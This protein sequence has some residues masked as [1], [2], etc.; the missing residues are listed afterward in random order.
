MPREEPMW[1]TLLVAADQIEVEAGPRF[2]RASIINRAHRLDPSHHEMAYGAMF[3]TMVIESPT[4]PASPVGKV[5]HR[6]GHGLYLNASS[7]NLET[8]TKPLN[9]KEET[10]GPKKGLPRLR[11]NETSQRLLS[12]TAGFDLY[13]SQ[14]AVASPFRRS[15]QLDFHRATIV[16]RRTLGTADAALDDEEFLDTLYA[17]LKAWGIGKRGSVLVERDL[18]GVALRKHREVINQFEGVSIDDDGLEAH[19]LAGPLAT[20][21]EKLGIVDN[22]S[23]IVAGTKALHH[24]LPD[25]V[26][27]M[28]R[29]WTG[30]FFGWKPSDPQYA[31]NRI[32]VEAFTSLVQVAREVNLSLFSDFEWFTS[33]SKCLDNALIG[34]CQLEIIG[35]KDEEKTAESVM[36]IEITRSVEHDSPH[37][38]EDK[39][40]VFQKTEQLRDADESSSPKLGIRR[41]RR[42]VHRLDGFLERHER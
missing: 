10:S 33:I 37:E 25:L 30:L 24:L 19:D 23:T 21:I 31:H 40:L 28:D 6:I 4:A 8:T 11:T 41:L 26:P 1:K 13:A 22:Q 32:F 34:Y 36:A 7:S 15:G 29:Q 42:I 35:L 38:R 16:R 20:L 14:F 27:P 39:S 5:F 9:S 17:T 12:L 3:Q 18:F 2:T